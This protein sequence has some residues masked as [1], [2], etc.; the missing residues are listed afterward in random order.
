MVFAFSCGLLISSD[1]PR[2]HKSGYASF[3]LNR[4]LKMNETYLLWVY[5]E[6]GGF[7][8]DSTVSKP[9]K[10]LLATQNES[11]SSPPLHKDVEEHTEVIPQE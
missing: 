2:L 5:E 6:E 4:I 9:L 7:L 8:I 10:T 3:V 1:L 11:V